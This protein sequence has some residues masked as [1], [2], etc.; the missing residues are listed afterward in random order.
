MRCG[1]HTAFP[2]GAGGTCC[3]MFIQAQTQAQNRHDYRIDIRLHLS[4]PSGLNLS[5]LPITRT[6][7]KRATKDA[8]NGEEERESKRERE[9]ERER[10]REPERERETETETERERERDVI[11]TYVVGHCPRKHD[12]GP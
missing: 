10:E 4:K 6:K 12:T 9:T 3:G 5:G 7:S 11:Q 8:L 2:A 1:H